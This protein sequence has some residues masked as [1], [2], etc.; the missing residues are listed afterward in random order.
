MVYVFGPNGNGL[1]LWPL[2]RALTGGHD[3]G[4]DG[5]GA[6]VGVEGLEEAGDAGDVGARH[7]CAGLGVEEDAA[8]VE[9]EPRRSGLAGERRQDAHPRRGDVRLHQTHTQV[10]LAGDLDTMDTVRVSE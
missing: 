9:G 7:G 8:A 2:H 1:R 5:G 6:P 3:G 4:L 10:K